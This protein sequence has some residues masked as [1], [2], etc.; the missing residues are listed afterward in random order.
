MAKNC[1]NHEVLVMKLIAGE[2]DMQFT[3]SGTSLHTQ[4]VG[5]TFG[6]LFCTESGYETENT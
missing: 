1:W 3:S 5:I 6:Y 4:H 2:K